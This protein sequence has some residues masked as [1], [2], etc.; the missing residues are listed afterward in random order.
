MRKDDV[1]INNVIEEAGLL[2]RSAARA[3]AVGGAVRQGLGDVATAVSG[4][5]PAPDAGWRGKYR[6]GKQDQILN[7]LSNDI[8]TDLTKLGLLPQGSPIN[9]RELKDILSKY[10]GKY[11]GVGNQQTATSATQAPA[12]QTATTQQSPQQAPEPPA[13]SQSTAPAWRDVFSKGEMPTTSTT[14]ASTAPSA[15]AASSTPAAPSAPSPDAAST[16]SPATSTPAATTAPVDSSSSTNQQSPAKSSSSKAKPLKTKETS[17]QDD[18]PNESTISD[19]KGIEYEYN[20]EDKTWYIAS[21]AGRSTSQIPN[22]TPE[23]QNSITKAWLE[24]SKKEKAE[25]EKEAE[26][27]V[28]SAFA[29]PEEEIPNESKIQDKKGTTYEYN[30]GDKKWY[31]ASQAGRSTSQIPNDRPE[32]QDSISKAWRNKKKKES[33]QE[34]PAFEESFKN[35]FWNN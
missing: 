30:S 35:Y 18:V 3:K 33:T 8:V 24:K 17:S 2:S 23:I 11:T 26:S 10:V 20:S 9:Q 21:Q 1:L 32:V 14:P 31:I 22:S 16:T 19:R 12:A 29:E 7:T 13:S 27:F 25:K 15:P 34:T 6:S 4:K 5:K 28:S